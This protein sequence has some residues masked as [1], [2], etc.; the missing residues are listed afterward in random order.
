MKN[1]PT[2]L[3]TCGEASGDLHAAN[4]VSELQKKIP[5]ARILAL[6]GSKVAE[7]GASL[8]YHID[9]YAMIGFSGV[10]ANLPKFLRLERGLKRVLANG[11]DLFVPVDYPGLNLRLAARARELKI[12]VLYYISPQVWAWGKRRIEKLGKSVDYMALI[13]PFEEQIYRDQGIPAEFV[14]HPLVEDH[15]LPTPRD[16][17]E[18]SGIGL[19]PGSRPQE[20]RRIL[21]VLLE[22]AKL[23]RTHRPQEKF[24]I[25]ASASV[26]TQLYSKI[27]SRHSVDAEI[28]HDT[29][30]L[31]ASS[32]LL[33]VA[34]GTATLQ[35]ALFETPLIIVYRLS[36]LNYLI[37]RKLVKI[38][39][40]GLVNIILG[41]EICPEFVQIEAKPRVIADSALSLL[42][43]PAQRETMVSKFG[44][45]RSMLAGPGGCRR[46]A[47]IS[48]Q[49]I[50]SS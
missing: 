17:R 49:L 36:L 1:A 42:E 5:D 19:L 47:E 33:L 45:L 29:Q 40:I 7:A 10:L 27:L 39:H 23:I 12:P 6:G 24:S 26:P 32:S 38:S 16:Q 22:T 28:K 31:M 25:G 41:E 13:L 35:G 30:A 11:V 50:E 21:P 44:A 4:L 2:I 20:V 15:E 9:D 46:V 43:N 37:A 48:H 34:S 18:R 14:G 8:L 3:V